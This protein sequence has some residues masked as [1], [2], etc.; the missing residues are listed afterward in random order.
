MDNEQIL[1]PADAEAQAEEADQTKITG[2]DSVTKEGEIES[3]RREVERLNGELERSRAE[4]ARINEQLAEFADVFPD[5][6][7]R[8][9]PEDVWESVR[10]GNSL[11]ASY[12]LY[13]QKLRNR[14]LR[15][16]SVNDR[17]AMVSSGRVTGNAPEHFTPDEVRAMSQSEVRANFS[18]IKESM[19]KWN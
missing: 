19:K 13:T 17:N 6:D 9:L 1:T 16:R 4:T 3:L 2:E 7:V 5:A 10:S 12:A 8:A 11:A 14:D 15:L 18:K